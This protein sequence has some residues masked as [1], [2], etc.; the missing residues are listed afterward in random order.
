[1]MNPAEGGCT[2]GSSSGR[3]GASESWSANDMERNLLK[4]ANESAVSSLSQS[5]CV[6]Q[7]WRIA[8]LAVWRRQLPGAPCVA[9][10]AVAP[11]PP[12]G[13]GEDANATLDPLALR[14][15]KKMEER[16]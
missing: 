12:R 13:R 8:R 10:A 16:R 4:D 15:L 3:S 1:M 7:G 2:E 14:S 5:Q 11:T 6:Y 9:V